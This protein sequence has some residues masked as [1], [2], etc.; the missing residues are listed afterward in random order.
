M[1]SLGCIINVVG[2][3]HSNFD[4][5]I[6][7]III[8]KIHFY[9]IILQTVCLHY[10]RRWHR[11]GVCH[12]QPSEGVLGGYYPCPPCYTLAAEWSSMA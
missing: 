2:Q 12:T 7:S 3:V 9:M 5:Y 6:F 1:N 8:L 10:L 4:V 11:G